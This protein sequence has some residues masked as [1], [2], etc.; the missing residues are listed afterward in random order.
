MGVFGNFLV[1]S[2]VFVLVSA[3][4]I[5]A[6]RWT[7]PGPA[8]DGSELNSRGWVIPFVTLWSGYLLNLVP[9]RLIARSKFV[10]HYIPALMI[11]VLLC[12]SRH[13]S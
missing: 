8:D 1:V 4:F 6:G 10:Y 7:E 3:R 5:L 9:Y 12:A 11:G 2:L 13:D